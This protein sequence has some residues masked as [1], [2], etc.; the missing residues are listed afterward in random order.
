MRTNF[1]PIVLIALLF[2]ACSEKPISFS[3]TNQSESSLS[4]K[5]IVVK[6]SDLEAK[7]GQL[8]EQRLVYLVDQK[9]EKILAQLDDT[10][11]KGTWDEL[12]AQVDLEAG[13][14]LTFTLEWAN[15]ADF[16]DVKYRTNIRF[17]DMN[18]ASKEFERADRL[19]NNDSE[20]T[21]KI[22]QFEGPGWENDVIGFRNFFDARNGMDIW[23]KVTS[24]MVLD[25]VGVK[26]A[27]TYHEMQA[28]GMDIL[29]VG[30]S[31][32]AGSIALQSAN[33]LYQVGPGAV[34][35]YKL[36]TEG[37]LRS[38][39]ELKFD[40]INI[41]GRLISV[42]HRITIE[43]GKP[44]YA[45]SVFV[46]DAGDAKLVTGMVNMQT[47]DVYYIP[48]SDI[49]YFFTHDKQ[50]YL[51]EH[52]GMAIIVPNRQ[53]EVFTTPD[54]GEGITQSYYTVMDLVNQPIEYYFMAGWE[55]QNPIYSTFEGF[56]NELKQQVAQI[57]AQIDVVI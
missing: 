25:K 23:G 7:F 2:V 55:V 12:Y 11:G 39:F 34:G 20:T 51:G 21:E 18:D 8:K 19:K 45:N 46:D 49:S 5:P 6:R 22:F 26:N 3:V 29:K 35:T 54:E 16:A 15:E 32:G 13:Q 50:S 28:W 9:G 47:N 36:I 42:S 10:R 27:P 43:A 30:N 53:I 4:A 24:E 14:T 40:R 31:L 57:A 37:P 38:T 48:G 17:A 52:L 44:F 33:Q 41:E 56:E 1:L